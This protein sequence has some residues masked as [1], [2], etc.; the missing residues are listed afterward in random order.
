MMELPVRLTLNGHLPVRKHST[1]AG[2]D[3]ATPQHIELRPGQSVFV[4]T[5]VAVKIPDG[6]F[7]LLTQRSSV[8]CL[9]ECVLSLG[10][11]DSSYI[12]NL[13]FRMFN[14]GEHLV[15]F[16]PGDRVA[17][18][19]IIPFIAPEPVEVLSLLDTERGEHGIGST[20]K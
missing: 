15:K 10:I 20:G 9:Y 6:H 4:D 8:G 2:M 12:G 18:L 19:V 1:D 5:C 3:I 17:Q 16:E 7:G 13:K 11:I 14:I